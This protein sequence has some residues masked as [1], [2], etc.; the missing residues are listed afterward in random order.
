MKT[1]SVAHRLGIKSP[2]T[3]ISW[4]EMFSE[5]F[6]EGAKGINGLQRDYNHNDVAILNTIRVARQR[7]T[8]WEEIRKALAEGYIEANLPL[9]AAV[10][11]GENA[12]AIYGQIKNLEAAL[13]NANAE[14]ERVRT[15]SKA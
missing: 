7:D 6:S 8:H 2:K 11:E 4:T 9:E 5:F 1:G 15:E 14:L 13:A 10:I 12:L 3:I